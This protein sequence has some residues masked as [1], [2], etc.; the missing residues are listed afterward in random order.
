VSKPIYIVKAPPSAPLDLQEQVYY[1][2]EDGWRAAKAASFWQTAS[3]EDRVALCKY[4]ADETDGDLAEAL[5]QLQ[6]QTASRD[7]EDIP[8]VDPPDDSPFE[9]TEPAA[10]DELHIEADIL[11]YPTWLDD[12]A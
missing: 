4:A 1:I 10:Y 6:E 5:L 8:P 2:P 11:M 7:N 12:E 9:Y 3:V